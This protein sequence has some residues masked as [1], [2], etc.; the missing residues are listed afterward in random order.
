LQN[1]ALHGAIA[2]RCPTDAFKLAKNA[3]H[4]YQRSERGEIN[5][6]RGNTSIM[7]LNEFKDKMLNQPEA[8]P[9]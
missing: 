3:C 4:R 7:Y 1:V 6:L 9:E 5:I 8:L 2:Y